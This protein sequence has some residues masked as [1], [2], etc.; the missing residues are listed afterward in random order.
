MLYSPSG[1]AKREA[2]CLRGSYK[3][4]RPTGKSHRTSPG[5]YF[6]EGRGV[7]WEQPAQI[8]NIMISVTGFGDERRAVSVLYL[9]ISLDGFK[10]ISN[11]ICASK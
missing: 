5:R 8:L 7:D 6:W 2:T 9:H 10:T 1:K 4:V 3:A 11:N